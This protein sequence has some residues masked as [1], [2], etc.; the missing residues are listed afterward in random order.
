MFR[1]IQKMNVRGAKDCRSA[2]SILS[3][4]TSKSK[5]TLSQSD[6][7]NLISKKINLVFKKREQFKQQAMRKTILNDN[8]KMYN[9]FKKAHEEEFQDLL[10]ERAKIMKSKKKRYKIEKRLK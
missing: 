6:R 8:G 2:Y 7:E 9:Q 1:G 10:K 4:Q 5:S 3:N